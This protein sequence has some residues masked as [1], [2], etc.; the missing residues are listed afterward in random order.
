M[1]KVLV[2]LVMVLAFNLSNAQWKTQFYVDDFGEKTNESYQ[3][4]VANGTFSNSAT[5]NAKALYKFVK[6]SDYVE[7][8]VFEYASSLATDTENTFEVV[9]LKTPSGVVTFD[10]IFFWKKGKL[11]FN[12][13]DF[14]KLSDALSQS[15]D[16]I[17]IFK[18]S[19]SYSES[20]YKIE[21]SM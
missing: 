4:F 21:F 6:G 7:L 10:K 12:E 3:F 13:A 1:K 16:F 17:M 20:S 14:N 5:Q 18:R 8:S 2:L 19:G 9:R 11:L 15:G